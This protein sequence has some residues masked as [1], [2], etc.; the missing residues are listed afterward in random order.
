MCTSVDYDPI[1]REMFMESVI[2][3]SGVEPIG[4]RNRNNVMFSV[5]CSHSAI[6]ID[7]PPVLRFFLFFF[8]FVVCNE[9]DDEPPIENGV[10][11]KGKPTNVIIVFTEMEFTQYARACFRFDSND[12]PAQTIALLGGLSNWKIETRINNN[13]VGKRSTAK[14]QQINEKKVFEN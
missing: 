4:Q 10:H 8:I 14:S 3:A 6:C 11:H 5:Q 9:D 1:L 12:E 7:F 2:Q 13:M